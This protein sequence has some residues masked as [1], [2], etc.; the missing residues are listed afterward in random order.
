MCAATAFPASPE[1]GL[2]GPT[3]MARDLALL[4]AGS[5]AYRVYTWREVW[6]TLGR[7]Q[8][9]AKTLVDPAGTRWI[10]RPTGGAAVL[11][12]HDVTVGLV[13]PVARTGVERTYELATRPLVGAL[14]RLGIET[15]LGREAGVLQPGPL[16]LDCFASA[17]R[18]DIIDLRTGAKICGCALRRTRSAVLMQAS[19]PAGVAS[20]EPSQVIRGGVRTG[21]VSICAE[22]LAA[23]LEQELQSIDGSRAFCK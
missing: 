5:P 6:V 4:E 9:P 18:N 12:G 11:H 8:V 16:A 14:G 1:L 2:D 17:S 21:F 10:T 19:I 23:C 22:D 13:L 3:A 7:N 20:V 15:R